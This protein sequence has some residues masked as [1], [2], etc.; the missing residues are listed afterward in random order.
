[1]GLPHPPDPHSASCFRKGSSQR[2]RGSS[3]L[4][5]PF[6]L[7]CEPC[8]PRL[9]GRPVAPPRGGA[10]WP[11]TELVAV[12][13]TG[14]PP[15]LACLPAHVH[16]EERSASSRRARACL[17]WVPLTSE[18]VGGRNPSPAATI[19]ICITRSFHPPPP[20]RSFFGLRAGDASR[21]PLRSVVLPV[22]SAGAA[23][24]ARAQA[25]RAGARGK[26]EV[27]SPSFLFFFLETELCRYLSRVGD[28]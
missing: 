8:S 6:V 3:E 27:F 23:G 22:V 16:E 9:S 13:A 18:A 28:L 21:A 12:P 4:G 11:P 19:Y 17:R 24:P 26:S 20:P 2:P 14:R 1:M 10:R 25:E 5:P 7:P 15:P